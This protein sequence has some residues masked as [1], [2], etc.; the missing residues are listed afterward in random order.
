MIFVKFKLLRQAGPG[1]NEAHLAA[2][3]VEELGQF[4]K[5]GTTNQPA[6]FDQAR[7]SGTIQFGHGFV[8]LDQMLD[9]GLMDI[10]GCLK[11]HAPELVNSEAFAI[12]A[13]PGLPEE[14]TSRRYGLNPAVGKRCN[15]DQKW[16]E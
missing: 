15:Y 4:I 13:H 11:V 1:P 16:Q 10:G 5:A 14:D 9:V 2:Q 3:D 8:G 6:P 12:P 7:V